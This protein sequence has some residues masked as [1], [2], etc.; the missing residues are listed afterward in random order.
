MLS[1]VASTTR[2]EVRRATPTKISSYQYPHSLSSSGCSSEKSQWWEHLCEV[3][4]SWPLFSCLRFR[5]QNK[6]QEAHCCLQSSVLALISIT[7]VSNARS[8]I[9]IFA[10][11]VCWKLSRFLEIHSWTWFTLISTRCVRYAD[12][13]FTHSASLLTER[14]LYPSQTWH[15]CMRWAS[16]SPGVLSELER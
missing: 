2:N 9:V 10:C 12:R 5:R 3:R 6:L 11:A 1:T 7:A 15:S 4:Q 14:N 8:R 13:S 16:R